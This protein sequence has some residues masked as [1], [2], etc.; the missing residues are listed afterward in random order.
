M[1]ILTVY[2]LHYTYSRCYV[3]KCSGIINTLC[4]TL[5][6]VAIHTQTQ[7]LYAR[8]SK[9]FSYLGTPQILI[10]H[11]SPSHSRSLESSNIQRMKFLR[12]LL[13]VVLEVI[14][15]ASNLH[16]PCFQ[17]GYARVCQENSQPFSDVMSVEY[18]LF[19][20]VSRHHW[21]VYSASSIENHYECSLD[22]TPTQQ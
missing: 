8:N 12:V 3:Y 16:A 13:Q 20:F 11:P 10:N 22:Q 4:S 7:S 17:Y 18:R 9:L 6:N 19:C 2:F 14:E 5:Y 1:Q 15:T 21:S